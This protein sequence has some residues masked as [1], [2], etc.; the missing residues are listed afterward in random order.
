[1]DDLLELDEQVLTFDIP[2][3]ALERAASTNQAYTL[4]HC[5]HPWHQCPWPQS[6]ITSTHTTRPPF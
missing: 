2:D 6:P 5:T 1:M 3:E 4:V